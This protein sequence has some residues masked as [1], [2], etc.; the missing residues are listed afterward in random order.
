MNHKLLLAIYFVMVSSLVFAQKS[1]GEYYEIKVY[2]FT[3]A[4]QETILDTYLEKAYLPALHKAGIKQVGVFKPVTN[5]TAPVKKVYVFITSP[6]LDKLA[7]LPQQLQKDS[8]YL[9]A[10]AEYMNAA[11]D[12][13]PF[14]RFETILLR[15]FRLAPQMKLPALKNNKSERIYELRSYEGPTE[16]LYTTKVKMF[17]EGGEISLFKRLNF[18]AVFYAEVVSGSQMP[19]LMYMTTFED[20]ADRD[21]HWETFKNDPEWKQLSALP[22]YQ[23]TV[24]KA[25]IILMKPAQYSDF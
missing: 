1:T 10:G 21:A 11:F 5:D 17:N 6:T 14:A 20:K 9:K 16:K 22:E 7:A 15:S 12:Q 24:S 18:N 4:E 13:P 2:R 8:T 3:K 25:E 23:H 19:N